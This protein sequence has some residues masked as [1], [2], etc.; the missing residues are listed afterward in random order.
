[1]QATED[2]S[3]K[4]AFVFVPFNGQH[5]PSQNRDIQTTIRKH[6]MHHYRG[7]QQRPVDRDLP[8]QRL[9][10]LAPASFS[11]SGA[12][13]TF[14]FRPRGRLKRAKLG[15]SGYRGLEEA[16]RPTAKRALAPKIKGGSQESDDS[17]QN[18][19]S[20]ARSSTDVSSDESQTSFQERTQC[21]DIGDGT[22]I[23]GELNQSS[24]TRNDLLF[25]E[26][27]FLPGGCQIDPFGVLP[28]QLSRRE[29]ILLD[30]FQ[31]WKGPTWC[32]V[33]SLGPWFSFALYDELLF[34]ATMFHWSCK[35][36]KVKES[37]CQ[38]EESIRHKIIA[39]RL[40][41]QRLQNPVEATKIE[42]LGAVA[43]LINAEAITG[44]LEEA[45]QHMVGLA[46][47]VNLNGGF[48]K[49][50][51][52]IGGILVKLIQWN[53]LTLEKQILPS[54]EN[55]E[56]VHSGVTAGSWLAQ[57]GSSTG[58]ETR[59]INTTLSEVVVSFFSRVQIFL[60][61]CS[62]IP[63]SGLEPQARYDRAGQLGALEA[64]LDN[65]LVALV[66]S[67]C[68]ESILG[69]PLA[70]ALSY[71]LHVSYELAICSAKPGPLS[72]NRL[73]DI[74]QPALKYQTYPQLLIWSLT[75]ACIMPFNKDEHQ[76]FLQNLLTVCQQQGI[77]EW[78][79]YRT[80]LVD[81]FW[82]PYVE[83]RLYLRVWHAMHGVD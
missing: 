45:R 6:V 58:S 40:I 26:P 46:S 36:I 31:R 43:A 7:Q 83:E 32:P 42:T 64:D 9:P 75:A 61:I 50:S 11:R 37:L 17:S 52:S 22:D 44:N 60:G 20:S 4:G 62:R 71:L 65:V 13:L 56:N 28:F 82:F 48:L 12:A 57:L 19:P 67:N 14:R 38:N 15:D 77:S 63:A 8:N 33:S 5:R 30:S 25:L 16:I 80:S 54:K 24:G 41:N 66:A 2:A 68:F 29:E 3:S 55:S 51:T 74:R 34:H 10:E 76:W 70:I 27:F 35:I 21:Q 53:H 81:F 59:R 73:F 39:I 49:L 69:A 79:Q 18:H 23:W 47:L 72:E 78:L 1:M